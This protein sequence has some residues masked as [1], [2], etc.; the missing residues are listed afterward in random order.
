MAKNV[1]IVGAGG[2]GSWLAFFL[3]DLNHHE[4]T[5][6]LLITF[7]D[8]DE[9]ET[10]NI[11]YQNFGIEDVT[12]YK[13]ESLAARYG[14]E[15]IAKRITEA[16]QLKDY[17]LIISCVDNP[18]FRRLLFTTAEKMDFYWIDLR[19]EGKGIA[20]YS[21]NKKNT[22]KKMLATLPKEDGED[23]SCQL[24]Y[25]LE[26]GIIQQGN[27]IVAAIGSQMLLNWARNENVPI[28]DVR[29]YG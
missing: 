29:L 16:K 9:V 21:K 27:K 23:K 13:V 15:K 8:D 17:D 2:I 20:F 5:D 4:Q 26:Q 7:A 19:S 6:H 10:K 1:L 28:E 18:A 24:E 11:K 25:E 12:D 14:F 3:D 22:L